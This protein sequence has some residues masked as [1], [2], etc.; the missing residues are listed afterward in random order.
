MGAHNDRGGIRSLRL[1]AALLLALLLAAGG[2]AK[3][4][5]VFT[6]ARRDDGNLSITGWTGSGEY[7]AVPAQI[8]GVR[9]A[10]IGDNAFSDCEAVTR[11]VLP[12]GVE[13]L[14]DG[15][16]A[17]CYSL[18]EIRVPASV[19]AVGEN[20]FAGCENLRKVELADG[21]G[22]LETING[23][24][25]GDGGARLIFCPRVLPMERYVVP[26]GTRRIDAR[27]FS[28]C[29]RLLSVT[30]PDSVEAIGAEAFERRANLTL[31]VGRGSY[32]ETYA[33]Q[34]GI[35]YTY[36]DAGEWLAD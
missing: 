9:V 29:N 22:C 21:S 12:E 8:E 15:A 35:K 30:L 17:D 3:S 11:I 16:F 36:S 4:S 19:A 7:I 2:F 18:E 5:G 33:V 31:V 24:L 26:E 32:G 28:Y 25:F 6:F 23:V 27:A 1:C 13:R 20:P 34:N 14:G 10:E